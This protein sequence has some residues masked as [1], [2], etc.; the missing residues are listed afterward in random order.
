MIQVRHEFNEFLEKYG[1]HIGYSVRP[2]ERRKGYAKAMLAAALPFCWHELGLDRV[3]VSCLRE[4]EGSRRTIL[5]NGGIY[6]STVLEPLDQ[7]YLER[8]WI[9][10]PR[11]LLITG[12]EPFGKDSLNPSW[13][14]VNHLPEKIGPWTLE[15][16]LLP[17]TFGEAA[18][19]AIAAAEHSG[20]DAAVSV[21]LAGGR[22]AVTVEM[23][24]LN[25]R[26]ASMADNAGFQPQDMPVAAGGPAAYF[27]TLPVR[28]MAQAVCEAGLAGA[29]SYS[30]GTY[31]CN[32]VMYSLLHHF[33]GT[34]VKAG[35]IHVPWSEG[36][37]E[38][39]WQP[40]DIVRALEAAI[41]AM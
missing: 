10:R 39:A 28:K 8:Y 12:F 11:R 22:R 20:A 14:A 3:L 41:R 26:Y 37:G 1:G 40:E 4:N 25:L 33:A 16:L 15:K 2:S 21:G 19:L 29:V 30:A 6:E 9:E 31:V 35:F 13:E 38:P 5:A 23:A 27:S 7:V 32:D 17:V 36:M 24:A 34:P 18:H